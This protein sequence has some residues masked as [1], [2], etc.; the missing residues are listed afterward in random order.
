MSLAA[1]VRSGTVRTAVL[2]AVAVLA[3]AAL[4]PP[5]IDAAAAGAAT[6]PGSAFV[7]RSG[8]VPYES[9]LAADVTLTVSVPRRTFAPGQLVR[10]AVAL[11]N[12]SAHACTAPFAG[13]AHGP[14]PLVLGPCSPV[15][16]R[17][18]NATGG[19]VY[20]GHVA[21]GCP[22][23][24]GEPIPPHQSIFTAGSWDQRSGSGL[25][26]AQQPPGVYTSIHRVAT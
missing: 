18:T 25:R 19:D 15:S 5:A 3:A 14:L 10:Y 16:V 24:I 12:D 7:V 21:L 17:I 8:H 9:C 4:V 1:H 6:T 22:A 26:G 20:P 23:I 13:L 11:K 2:A